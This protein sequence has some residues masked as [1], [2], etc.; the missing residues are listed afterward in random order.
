MTL[1]FQVQFVRTN[2]SSSIETA[3]KDLLKSESLVEKRPDKNL[4][5]KGKKVKRAYHKNHEKRNE[6]KKI[7][8]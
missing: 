1:Y 3:I 7:N 5:R 8:N 4:K 2:Y 6:Y